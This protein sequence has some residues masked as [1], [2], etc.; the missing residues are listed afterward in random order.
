MKLLLKRKTLTKGCHHKNEF[1]S[2]TEMHAYSH[3][4]K[5]MMHAAEN[6][7]LQIFT[8]SGKNRIYLFFI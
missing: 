5:N 4:V 6:E 1:L 8:K 3:V 2:L 7:Y